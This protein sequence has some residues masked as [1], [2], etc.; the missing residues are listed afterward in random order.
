MRNQMV[1]CVAVLGA[2]CLVVAALLAAINYVTAPIIAE[3]AKR[4]EEKAYLAVLPDATGFE[5]VERTAEVPKTVTEIRR[6][7]GGSGYAFMV[8]MSGYGG[9]S[10]PITAIVGID[11]NGKITRIAVTDVSGESAGIGDKV[12]GKDYLATFIGKDSLLNGVNTI[13]GATVSSSGFIGGVK[14]AF[15][16]FLAVA[17]FEETDAQKIDRLV[18]TVID[19][20]TDE[21]TF[22]LKDAS[23]GSVIKVQRAEDGRGYAVA[24]RDG[25]KTVIAGISPF[26]KLLKLIDL[27]GNDLTA[28]A[29]EE[30]ISAANAA[31]SANLSAVRERHR[32]DI[33]SL[34]ADGA[35]LAPLAHKAGLDA[36]V[37]DAYTVSGAP[38]A[39]YAF[40]LSLDSIRIAAVANESGEL[41]ASAVLSPNDGDASELPVA[42]TVLSAVNLFKEV[43][44][45]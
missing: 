36:S 16:A 32:Y 38:G 9:D 19:G 3:R 44:G 39:A 10:A 42:E 17:E 40:V 37:I 24:L 1:K 41:L 12:A 34:L 8:K 29:S 30:L 11:A 7:K 23:V 27:D 33:S 5:T 25:E 2:I 14:D 18:Y 21:N 4:D 22:E 45:Q 31:I 6:D 26:G 28:N 35:S 43:S 20:M 15:D 13:S